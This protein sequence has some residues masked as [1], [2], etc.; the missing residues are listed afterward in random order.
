MKNIL[1]RY[2]AGGITVLMILSMSA[3]GKKPEN[4]V[5]NSEDNKYLTA[6]Y[7]LETDVVLKYWFGVGELKQGGQFVQT[8]EKNTGIKIEVINASTDVAQRKQQFS[9][10]L[11][12]NDKPD[13][14]EYQWG[15]P[16]YISGGPDEAIK[17]KYII[18]LNNLL[19]TASPNFKKYLDENPHIDKEVRTISGQYYIYPF[20]RAYDENR[21]FQGPMMRKDWLDSLGLSVP[22]TIDDWYTVLK[23]FKEKKGAT[24]PLT[25]I[26][27]GILPHS[28]FI[29]AYGTG[30]NFYVEDGKVKYGQIEPGY[31][32]FL[33]TMNKWYQEGLLDN[34]LTTLDVATF[35]AKMTNGTS[36]AANAGV[37]GGLGK[38]LGLMKDANPDY[39][40]IAVPYPSSEKGEKAMFNGI[41]GIYGG[42]GAAISTDSKH[43]ILAAKLLDY[44]YSEE[45][46]TF[47]AFGTEGLTYEMIDGYPTYT[48]Y[49][50]KNPDGFSMSEILGRETRATFGPCIQSPLYFEQFASLP[51]QQAAIKTWA[52]SGESKHIMPFVLRTDAE[53]KEF[54][55][56]Y[57]DINTY[58]RESMMGF[59]SGQK[60]LSE[61]DE[62]ISTLKSMK[63]ERAIEIMQAAYDRYSK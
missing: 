63:I 18:S 16:Q 2:V 47:S 60:S 8:L 59:I 55:K 58:T 32:D 52:N 35:D 12:S 42:S 57:S 50:M 19:D 13:I 1:K 26:V 48:D 44:F 51:Q 4:A 23:A 40:L 24:A 38:W 9:L 34:N 25:F 36:G 10:L 54:S 43:P 29:G 22:E 17:S 53:E 37:G 20:L 33:T 56:M 15:D 46:N 21:I 7:P 27:D 49:V 31:K 6:E 30:F 14:M 39:D 11:A 62:Y 45:G 41:S 28:L 5:D 61:Y 3:C